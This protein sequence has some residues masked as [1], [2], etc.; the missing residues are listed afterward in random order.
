MNI[1]FY[2]QKSKRRNEMGYNF[3]KEDC[4]ACSFMLI[5]AII[6]FL[7]LITL[8]MFDMTYEITFVEVNET[9]LLP[10]SNDGDNFLF[11]GIEDEAY[12][13]VYIRNGN[14]IEKILLPKYSIEIKEN[15]LKPVLKEYVS[16][17][18]PKNQ[19]YDFLFINNSPK[20]QWEICIP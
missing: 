7:L 5:L 12:Y 16:I 15:S 8:I 1:L 20:I 9:K 10:I 19:F 2:A 6:V 11:Y 14:M 17:R 18:T 4:R 13:F 3:S